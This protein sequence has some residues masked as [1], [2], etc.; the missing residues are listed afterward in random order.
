M[1]QAPDSLGGCREDRPEVLEQ[2]LDGRR[3]PPRHIP[4]NLL[5][6]IFEFQ[7]AAR[8]EAQLTKK[9]NNIHFLE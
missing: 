2:H 3:A 7:G 9:E 4:I 5:F 6:L 8:A 1:G